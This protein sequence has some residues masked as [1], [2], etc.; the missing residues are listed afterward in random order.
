MFENTLVSAIAL[1]IIIIQL[2]VAWHLYIK[3]KK[4]LDN[5]WFFL[6]QVSLQALM[7]TCVVNYFPFY[8]L[9]FFIFFLAFETCSTL[10]IFS[11]PFSAKLRKRLIVSLII[12]NPAA[13][14]LFR[15]FQGPAYIWYLSAAAGFLVI[16]IITIARK[17]KLLNPVIK[18]NVLVVSV[19]TAL[20]CV[21]LPIAFGLSITNFD[22]I[23]TQTAVLIFAPAFTFFILF[24]MV[25]KIASGIFLS[26]ARLGVFI[27]LALPFIL[28]IIELAPTRVFVLSFFSTDNFFIP[29]VTI[30]LVSV[31]IFAHLIIYLSDIADNYFNAS[32]AYYQ[33]LTNNFRIKADLFTTHKDLL[34]HFDNVLRNSFGG[35]SGLKYVMFSEEE[36]LSDFSENITIDD[37]LAGSTLIKWF[38][39]T[40][41]PFLLKRNLDMSHHLWE[42]IRKTG[43]DLIVPLYGRRKAIGFIAVSGKS[44]K[45]AAANCIAAITSTTSDAYTKISLFN[46][47]IKSEK[48]LQENKHFHETEKMVSVIAH[49]IR[50]P[51]TSIMFNMDVLMESVKPTDSFD[52]EYLDIA[53]KEI[54]K[55]NDAV[56]KM[57]IFGR[58][59]KLQP[60]PGT[61]DAFID[62]IKFVFSSAI[63]PIEFVNRTRKRYSIDWDRLKNV[64]I[65]MINNS[66]QAIEKSGKE[67]R[68]SVAISESKGRLHIEF[69]DTGPGIPPEAAASIF[70]PFFTTK[71]E[72]NGLGLAICEK[73]TRL[74][75]G[76][77]TLAE[78]SPA[79][80]VFLI[81]IPAVHAK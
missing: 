34:Y 13:L 20:V 77:I 57:L 31:N 21:M 45:T 1:T 52:R 3:G 64:F 59:I 56:E 40:R 22:I 25:R 43:A 41:E 55:L 38:E 4:N 76:T 54:R 69:K 79:G 67:G 33:R 71:K 37:S 14:Y 9:L 75:E 70:E 36:L 53:R 10:F 48:K 6:S 81:T 62:E 8:S 5:L 51:L 15:F 18:K 44:L 65:N 7:T 27:S 68:I 29:A 58:D 47:I 63:V 72:G 11:F 2:T 39:S 74:M 26:Y 35:T 50:T 17:R 23:F 24:I 60:E 73:I 61:F 19:T 32:H 46:E 80:T 28:I 42:D 66:L 30:T 12:L 49:E 16:N 78:T